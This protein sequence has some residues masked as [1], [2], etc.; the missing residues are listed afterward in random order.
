MSV[1][2]AIAVYFVLWWAVL[3]AALARGAR[4]RELL[5]QDGG[6]RR[7]WSGEHLTLKFAVTTAIAAVLF[8]LGA[9][10]YLGISAVLRSI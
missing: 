6:A 5:G 2:V 4:A 10:A 1:T 9:G 8:A 3:F 7:Y